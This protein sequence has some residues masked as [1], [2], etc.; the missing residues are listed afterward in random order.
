VHSPHCRYDDPDFFVNETPP[1][2]PNLK[3]CIERITMVEA[4][5]LHLTNIIFLLGKIGRHLTPPPSSEKRKL[6]DDDQKGRKKKSGASYS[7]C[8]IQTADTELAG[9]IPTAANI[10]RVS[11]EFWGGTLCSSYSRF[12]SGE[13]LGIPQ[14]VSSGF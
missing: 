8:P 11:A 7:Q 13:S 1:F 9:L 4:R 2:P 14:K 5:S 3:R 6:N 12:E 10:S